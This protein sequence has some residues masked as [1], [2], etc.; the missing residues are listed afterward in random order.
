MEVDALV[1]GMEDGKKQSWSVH[2]LNMRYD[3]MYQ[4]RWYD[5]TT[6][7]LR[8]LSVLYHNNVQEIKSH[9]LWEQALDKLNKK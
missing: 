4:S 8:N 1:A 3:P 6:Q 9:L 7:Q 5:A 2:L